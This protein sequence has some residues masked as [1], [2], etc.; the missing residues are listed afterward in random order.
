M[1]DLSIY[2]RLEKSRVDSSNEGTLANTAGNI[3][4]AHH[5]REQAVQF[6][7]ANATQN[8]AEQPVGV[9][10]LANI[11]SS[12]ARPVTANVTTGVNLTANATTAW[13]TVNLWKRPAANASAQTLVATANI[14]SN[15]T[16]WVPVAL[17]PVANGANAQV[18]PGDVLTVSILKGTAGLY[19]ANGQAALIDFAFEDV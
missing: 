16:A 5:T 2:K 8:L 9:V 3:V 7:D 4:V 12:A 6:T 18:A 17:T 14:T 11:P 10:S 13:A 1:S 15:V 19:F